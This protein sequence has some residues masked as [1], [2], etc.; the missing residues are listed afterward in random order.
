MEVD[1]HILL[2]KT[3]CFEF[4]DQD[5][6]CFWQYLINMTL[7][8]NRCPVRFT[9]PMVLGN[10]GSGDFVGR[11]RIPEPPFPRWP[12]DSKSL[13][14]AFCKWNMII[15]IWLLIASTVYILHV[16]IFMELANIILNSGEFPIL[17]FCV[18]LLWTRLKEELNG[19]S[20]PRISDIGNV[21]IRWLQQMWF[22]Y[23]IR[24]GSNSELISHLVQF[25]FL[26]KLCP[27]FHSPSGCLQ[28]FP[29]YSLQGLYTHWTCNLPF[30]QI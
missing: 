15:Y 14:S 11:C 24:F 4:T 22:E 16:R 25:Y 9:V 18:S 1:V 6:G 7:R 20:Q 28:Y 13:A 12:R 30:E 23:H 8:S 10:I 2:S 19:R 26:G 5:V 3:Q 27:F 21:D 29:D 17:R